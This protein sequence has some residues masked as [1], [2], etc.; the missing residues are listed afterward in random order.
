MSRD[1]EILRAAAELFLEHGYAKVRVD[2]I[3]ARAGISG[4]AIYHHFGS[5]D[6]ILATLF[7]QPMDHLLL[8][9]GPTRDGD[10]HEQLRALLVAQAE[11][12]VTDR[13]LV[14]VYAREGR[15][16]IEPWRRQ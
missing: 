15:S 16:L 13:V 12:A 6:E 2:D 11:F 8:L 5:Q 14:S 9:V 10:P 1:S 4:P 7:D 3:G